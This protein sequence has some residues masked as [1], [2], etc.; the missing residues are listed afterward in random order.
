MINTGLP[1]YTFDKYPRVEAGS[2]DYFD[3]FVKHIEKKDS[4]IR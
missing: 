3:A 2:A 1:V 4:L